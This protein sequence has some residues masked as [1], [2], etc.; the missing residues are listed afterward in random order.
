MFKQVINFIFEKKSLMKKVIIFLFVFAGLLSLNSCFIGKE[1]VVWFPSIND[2]KHFPSHQLKASPEPFHFYKAPKTIVPEPIIKFGYDST[3]SFEQFL[4]KN[5]TIAFLI[6]RNDT[7]LYE[8]YF[9]GYAD[10]IW[11]S[12]FSMAKSF[13]SGLIG[14]AVQDGLIN[15]NDPITKYVPGLKNPSI[16]KVTIKHLLQMTSGIKYIEHYKNPFASVALDY[17]GRNLKHAFHRLK[18]EVPPGTRFKYQ[19]INTQLLGF[20]LKNVLNNKTLTEYMQE[21]IWTP[22]GAEYPASWSID[23]RKYNM[24]K[25]FCCINATA[26]D[27][28]KYGRLYLNKGNWNGKQLLDKNWIINS[29]KIDSSEGSEPYY[30]YQWWL[31]PETHDFVADGLLGQFIYVSPERNLIM[32]R[33]GK[34]EGKINF[35]RFL[36]ELS[37][38][39]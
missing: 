32:V 11:G 7:I 6:I 12:S 16:Q 21:K 39:Y 38:Q 26:R 31:P 5:N 30:Q 15:I 3:I 23:S 33:L 27:F 9:A 28:A 13:T 14:F 18:T 2:Y 25:T 20:A 17:Y 35:W 10:S 22:V 36:V 37:K 29:T 8:H 4:E 24:E 1:M 34:N 19:S